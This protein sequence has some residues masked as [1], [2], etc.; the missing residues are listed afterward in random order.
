MMWEKSKKSKWIED[1]LAFNSPK[2][3]REMNLDDILYRLNSEIG[4]A[5]TL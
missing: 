3:R 4:L 2:A 5:V 1:V